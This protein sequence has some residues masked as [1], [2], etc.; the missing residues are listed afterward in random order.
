M[1]LVLARPEREEGT[2]FAVR[3]PFFEAHPV[4]TF[5]FTTSGVDVAMAHG[6]DRVPVGYLV[7]GRSAN[8]GV[9]DGADPSTEAMLVLRSS[10][11]ATVKVVAL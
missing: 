7:L 4:L 1:S 6:L 2:V 8:V 3:T 9:Y 10:G 11:A 5:V